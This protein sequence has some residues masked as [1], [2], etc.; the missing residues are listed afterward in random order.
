M[1]E[2]S[3]ESKEITQILTDHPELIE[4]ALM[5]VLEQA[6]IDGIDLEAYQQVLQS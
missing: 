6:A 2:M 5:L 1:N 3:I 4:Q